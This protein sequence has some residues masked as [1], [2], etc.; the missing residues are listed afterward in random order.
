M[1]SY[2]QRISLTAF[3]ATRECA[4]IIVRGDNSADAQL[5]L[6]GPAH[7]LEKALQLVNRYGREGVQAGD[8]SIQGV[9][10]KPEGREEA[11]QHSKHNHGKH[12]GKAMLAHSGQGLGLQRWWWGHVQN[13]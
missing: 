4:R 12:W 8:S 3:F 13:H 10:T 2:S 5:F 9:R 7:E 6:S 11:G 1:A